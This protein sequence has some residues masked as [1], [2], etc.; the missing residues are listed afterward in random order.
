MKARKLALNLME[1]GKFKKTVK[2]L[3]YQHLED[4][5]KTVKERREE[6]DREKEKVTREPKP[7]EVLP[8]PGPSKDEYEEIAFGRRVME[9]LGMRHSSLTGFREWLLRICRKSR[10]SHV[11]IESDLSVWSKALHLPWPKSFVEQVERER[12]KLREE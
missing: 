2:Y 9:H 7:W 5:E 4:F 11:R 6:L 12:E 1:Y 10:S 8:L 3:S